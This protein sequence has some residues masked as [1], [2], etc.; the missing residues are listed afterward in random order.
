[1]A[2]EAPGAPVLEGEADEEEGDSLTLRDCLLDLGEAIDPFT[3]SVGQLASGTEEAPG[4][5]VAL[6]PVTVV[7]DSCLVAV[8][9]ACW[10]KAIARSR[11]PKRCLTRAVNVEVAAQGEPPTRAH[12]ALKV[13]V[14]IGFLDREQEARWTA[15]NGEEAQF[16][17]RVS[18]SP[19]T[20]ALPFFPAL[21][22]VAQEQFGFETGQSAGPGGDAPEEPDALSL[23]VG[24]IE[25]AL[26]SVQLGLEKLLQQ[27]PPAG[28]PQPAPGA[29]P[30]KAALVEDIPAPPGLDAATVAEARKAGVWLG[31]CCSLQ[32]CGLPQAMPLGTRR[33]GE[34]HRIHQ[35]AGGGGFYQAPVGPR[36]SQHTA[37]MRGWLEHR[38]HLPGLAGPVRWAWAVGGIADCLAAGGSEEAHPRCLLLLAACD[39]AAVDSGSWLLGAE[40][41]F[42]PSA[43]LQAFARHRTPELHEQQHTRILDPRWISVAMAR[44]KEREAFNEVRRKLG[45]GAGRP[46]GG[47]SSSTNE[48]G[49][50]EK[51]EKGGKGNRK[52]PKSE[53]K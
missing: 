20:S 1:M 29:L 8:P 23:R 9:H 41:L 42:E 4:V 52:G 36:P 13:K 16:P 35:S 14:W 39:Q 3:V 37:T 50:K 5:S 47:G 24:A 33:A 2:A 53:A 21:L 19:G 32:G 18:G 12:A 15:G 7:E 31:R 45:A 30:R 6:V 49:D 22:Q 43:P 40:F 46:G 44:V 17:F 28:A 10:N 27:R 11:L 26:S 48:A 51:E 25:K 34:D 38:S